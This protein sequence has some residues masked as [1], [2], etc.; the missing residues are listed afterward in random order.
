M[1]VFC[2]QF[3]LLSDRLCY[4]EEPSL[5][6]NVSYIPLDR[7][8]VRPLP[9]HY[10]S[11]IGVSSVSSSQYPKRAQGCVFSVHCGSRTH[12]MAAE[13]PALC[14]VCAQSGRTF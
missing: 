5:G 10:G 4:T 2:L 13:S 11:K 7:I 9:R 6:G 3:Y 1:A 14:K 12:F 8:P